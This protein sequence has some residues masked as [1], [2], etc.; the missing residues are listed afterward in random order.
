[1]YHVSLIGTEYLN[2]TYD[3]IEFCFTFSF[4]NQRRTQHRFM[5]VAVSLAGV[6]AKRWGLK[7]WSRKPEKDYY[8]LRHTLVNLTYREIERRVKDKTVTQEFTWKLD[9]SNTPKRMPTFTNQYAYVTVNDYTIT[10]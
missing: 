10:A 4:T 3:A 8:L 6:V 9:D 5:T 1:M 7:I 2:N